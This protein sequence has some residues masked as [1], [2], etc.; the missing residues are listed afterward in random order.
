MVPDLNE[1]IRHHQ[2]GRLDDAMKIYQQLLAA[3][4]HHADALHLSGL[5]RHQKGDYAGA[6]QLLNRAIAVSPS[7]PGFHCNLG[8]V[9][10]ANGQL[11]KAVHALQTAIR[12]DPKYA[13]AYS[14]L[15]LALSAQGKYDEAIAQFERA[16]QLLPK[17]AMAENNLGN[18]Y[19][20]KGDRE[21]ALAHF[22]KAVE[23]GPNL[24]QARSNLGQF[25]VE[26]DQADEALVHCQEAV[27][28]APQMPE[29]HNNLGN[30]LREL[31]KIDEA[32]RSYQEALRLEPNIGMTFNNM[33]QAL[34]EEGNLVEARKWYEQAL[35]REPTL[36]R[37]HCN[38][39]SA[40]EAD[41]NHAEARARYE[42]ALRFEPNS[43]E[44]HAGLASLD[45]D[46][47]QIKD[48]LGHI[49]EAIRLKPD[50]ASAHCLNGTLLEELG[51]LDEAQASFRAALQR[52]PRHAAAYS[53]LATML[54]SRLSDEDR[55][56]MEKLLAESAEFPQR[57]T[58]LHY[59]LAQV[60]DSRGEYERAGEHLQH[61]N[62]LRLADWRQRQRGYQPAD[63]E[64][65]VDRLIA[66]FTPEFFAQRQGWGLDNLR[67]IFIVG[68]PRSGT[69]LTEQ[70]LASHSQV[71]GAGELRLAREG[72][73]SIPRLL[74]R[75]AS[76]MDCLPLLD[77]L[78]VRT[79][80]QQHLDGL[81][82]LDEKK[83]RVVD[84]M[85]DNYLYLGWLMLL[86]PRAKFIHTRR[87]VRDTAVSCWMTNFKSIRWAC[88]PEHIATRFRNYLRLMDYWRKVLPLSVLEID[89]EETVRD[90]DAVAKRLVAWCGLEWEEECLAFHKTDR[91]VRTAS[92]TQVRQPVYTRSVERWRNYEKHLA[93]LFQRLAS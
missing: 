14:N 31:G 55:A 87:D 25:L 43:A 11:D 44:A 46:D 48:A 69:T 92:V 52:S 33:G 67:P 80:A 15:G 93:S 32:K 81:R 8:E 64:R 70:I 56:A 51:K 30:V 10:R 53:Q 41:D 9:H 3:Q 60:Y 62:A 22:R 17:F 50:L 20:L 40:W 16:L 38:L 90:L 71:F 28:L 85:P 74:N 19:R 75:D 4:P 47:G 88:D 36:A 39:A 5:A 79:L 35:L 18:T 83:P 49:Q 54:K 72:F 26:N 76:S 84:K 89:Y 6:V 29:A 63:H 91:P 7:V 73:E 82:L 12:L 66:T 65:F 86:F 77:R 34:Q 37:F 59:G 23:L 13:E 42:V 2:A 78:N 58:A 21:R 24:A 68:M 27:R 1:A 45:H 57:R 61:A